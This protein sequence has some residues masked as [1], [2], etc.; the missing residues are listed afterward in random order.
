MALP[1]SIPTTALILA[2]AFV[3]IACGDGKKSTAKLSAEPTKQE[4]PTDTAKT[5]PPKG[6]FPFDFPTVP[7]SA[8]ANELVLTPS[9]EFL[10]Q[11]IEKGGDQ[12]TFIFYTANVL[13]AGATDS[14]VKS[15]AGTESTMPNAMIIPL[16]APTTAAKG[17]IVLTWWQSGSGM[18][19]A[20]VVDAGNGNEPTVRYLDLDY[21]NP[22]KNSEGVPIGQMEE[23]LK[24]ASFRKLT[25]E[26]EPGTAIA[27]REGDKFK[28][29][30]VIR[31]EGEKVLAIGFAGRVAVVNK[32]DCTPLPV[33]PLVKAG[34]NVHVPIVG[35]F[36]PGVVKRVD[37][38]IGRVFVDAE[39][40]GK[41]SEYIIAFGDVATHLP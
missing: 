25:A 20:I 11:A 28:H 22:A 36:K 41:T 3:F 39:F 13:E 6:G 31:V 18:Q 14:K 12:A 9:R 32:S 16:G 21:D 34:D 5:A 10:D 35:S 37:E 15:L 24:P 8:K 27:V 2:T 40:G 7:T 4:Q 26:W 29:W 30:Q 33:K 23:K 17:D 19:R 1:G 38:R